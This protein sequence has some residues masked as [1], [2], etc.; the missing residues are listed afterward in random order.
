MENE[1]FVSNILLSMREYQKE[2][3]IKGRCITNVLYYYDVLRMCLNITANDIKAKAVYVLGYDETKSLA[4]ICCGHIVLVFE[5]G[6]VVE[7]SYEIYKM[8]NKTYY[9]NI[10]DLKYCIEEREDFNNNIKCMLEQYI[11]FSKVAEQIN[12]GEFIITDKEHY[13]KQADY[14]QNKFND[15]MTTFTVKDLL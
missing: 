5:D 7:P 1:E 15:K 9:D 2:N 6:S 4:S 8:K 3:N 14:I 10:K 13:H 11:K 12:N